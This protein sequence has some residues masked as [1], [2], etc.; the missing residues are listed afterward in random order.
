MIDSIHRRWVSR[1]TPVLTLIILLLPSLP[2]L[3]SFYI[4]VTSFSDFVCLIL[5]CAEDTPIPSLHSTVTMPPR[6]KRTRTI[7]ELDALANKSDS[8]DDD[9]SDHAAWSPRKR[10]KAKK[11]SRST[12][13]RKRCGDS[14]S[15]DLVSD[16]ASLNESDDLAASDGDAE[17]EAPVLNLRGGR[18]RKAARNQNYNLGDSSAEDDAENEDSNAD[19]GEEDQPVSHVSPKPRKKSILTLKVGPRLHEFAHTSSNRRVTRRRGRSEDMDA[20]SSSGHPATHSPEAPVSKRLRRGSKTTSTTKVD[21]VEEENDV[22]MDQDE[23]EVVDETTMEIRGS[24]PEV[25]ESDLQGE[26]E[27][28]DQPAEGDEQVNNQEEEGI[29]PESENGDANHENAKDTA[30]D[31]A[32]DEDDEGPTTR[33]RSRRNQQP[34]HEEEEETRRP[35]RPSRKQPPRNSQR[36]PDEESDFQPEEEDSHDEDEMSQSEEER[37]PSRKESQAREEDEDSSGTRRPGLRRRLPRSTAQS[38][39]GGDIAEELAEELED[40]KGS[41]SRRRLQPEI[42]YEKPR[43]SRKDVDYRIIRPDLILPIEEAENEVT[44]SP[45]RRGRGGGGWQRTLFPTYGPFGGGGPSAI[46][47]PPGAH[48]AGGVDSDSSDD[49]VMQHPKGSG[50]P[51]ATLPGMAHFAAA[52]AHGA[53]QGLSGTPANLGKVKDKQALAD[54]DPLGVDVN[55]N[56][57]S[58][59]GLQGHIDQLKEMVSLP[60]LYPEIF[61]RFH[62]VPPRG[63]LFH[64]PPGTGKTL[65]ARALA[66]SVSSEGR[67]VTFYMRKG[68]DALSKWVGEAE[69]QL[70]LLFDEARKTQPSII[71]FDEID[72]KYQ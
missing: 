11:P 18:S 8:S 49:E 47:G 45:S 55:V 34:E 64:G 10:P 41:R 40:L 51:S 23:I 14:D 48:A 1:F 60:L 67:K 26:P 2:S 37:G 24:Q 30:A 66:N 4:P 58:V 70:R 7:Q 50:P 17:E 62:I 65:L 72:G 13:K 21:G 6:P 38:D 16:D 29:V 25:F 44:E 68:A 56:F 19:T 31:N 27:G 35:R 59:G 12:K 33:R 46:L 53:D 61:Q 57:E 20:L 36:K 52:Q 22:E 63:V 9:Y 43:R 39:A 3:S 5:V 69:R 42:V 54:A 71:F 28:G 15:D 32:E